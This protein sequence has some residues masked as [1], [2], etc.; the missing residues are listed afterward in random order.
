M[1][2]WRRFASHRSSTSPSGAELEGRPRP[3]SLLLPGA[4]RRPLRSIARMDPVAN[5]REEIR[6]AAAELAPAAR[7]PAL[8]RPPQPDLGDY[9]TNA[10]ML[11]APAVGQ[12]PRQVASELRGRLE[13]RLGGA[14]RVEVAG[15]GFLNLFLSDRWYR[16]GVMAILAAGERFG[17]RGSPSGTRVLVEFVSA[18]PTGPL[19]VGGG[20]NAAFG[21]SVARILAFAGDEVER[22]YYVNDAGRQVEL[23]AESVAARMRGAEPPADGY[24]G[25]YVIDLAGELVE[26][27]GAA[28]DLDELGRVATEAMRRR[29]EATLERFRV[30]FD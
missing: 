13:G 6:I 2:G 10:A 27:G 5:L 23:F 14:A 26:G 9:S 15:P 16:V 4:R 17:A 19:H 30:R 20:R 11:L 29:I 24:A 21:D 22:E 18:N 25:D 28:D 12:P 1:V 7:P 3:M 8:E